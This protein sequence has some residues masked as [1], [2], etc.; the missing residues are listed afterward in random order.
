MLTNDNDTNLFIL[1]DRHVLLLD[2]SSYYR[3]KIP[4]IACNLK[5]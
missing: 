2:E 4:T 1:N 5:L 3:N